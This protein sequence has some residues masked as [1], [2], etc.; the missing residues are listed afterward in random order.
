MPAQM[1][2]AAPNSAH[3][4]PRSVQNARHELASLAITFTWTQIRNFVS[5]RNSYYFILFP[6]ST[7]HNN[8][9][10]NAFALFSVP[11]LSAGFPSA[12]KFSLTFGTGNNAGTV[13]ACNFHNEYCSD[14]ITCIPPNGPA[15]T[16]EIATGLRFHSSVSRSTTFFKLAG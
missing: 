14:V 16:V 2:Y 8:S 9:S 7:H 6:A 5:I 15:E 4:N 1:R 12:S 10:I 3:Q 11:A 13:H